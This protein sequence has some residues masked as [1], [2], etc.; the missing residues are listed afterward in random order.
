[1]IKRQLG[2][3]Y[4]VALTAM[5]GLAARLIRGCMLHPL[6]SLNLGKNFNNDKVWGSVARSWE[7]YKVDLYQQL[8]KPWGG[9]QVILLGDFYQ[10]PPI[11][12]D[13]KVDFW[14]FK[15]PALTIHIPNYFILNCVL[16]HQDPQFVNFLSNI[17]WGVVDQT[18]EAYA[19]HLISMPLHDASVTSL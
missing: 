1:M 4:I 3:G 8:Q 6:L 7:L 14:L 5:M 13:N 16:Q 17:C 9:I 2:T 11:A 15:T 19:K 18:T 10:L 12:C